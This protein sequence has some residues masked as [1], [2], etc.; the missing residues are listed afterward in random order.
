VEIIDVSQGVSDGMAVW[1]GD[2]A[3]AVSAVLRVAAGDPANVSE[4]RFGTHTGTHVDPPAHFFDGAPGADAL[5]LDVLLGDAVV[6][7]V[8]G[9]GGALGPA[10]L[11]AVAP[12]GTTRLLLRTGGAF[13]RALSAASA[14]WLV[15]RGVRLVG[16]DG[17][18]IEAPGA[19]AGDGDGPG[20]GPGAAAGGPFPVHTTLLR[21]GVVIV[22]GLDLS[23]VA[24]GAYELV[25]LPLKLVGGD[26]G[27]A[28]AV[29]I[30]R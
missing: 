28:R 18:S 20:A 24:P 1:P 17:P 12:A 22:E 7:D 30:R 3:V 19:G 15:E 11:G 16:I 13:G 29:L 2:P 25:C 9:P 8:A 21:A 23:G 10:D 6:A 14:A 27:P 26:G 4:L 5:A